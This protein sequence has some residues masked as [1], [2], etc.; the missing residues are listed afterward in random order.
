MFT[1]K[2]VKGIAGFVASM[3]V[4]AVVSNVIV[5]T[6]PKN[7]TTINRIAVGIGGFVLS[8]MVAD[9]ASEY[10]KNQIDEISN[11]FK[12]AKEDAI[13]VAEDAAIKA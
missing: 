10:V 8:S 1:L 11:E 13:K 5:A 4:G 2:L 12:K 9:A 6:T 7:L 3:S